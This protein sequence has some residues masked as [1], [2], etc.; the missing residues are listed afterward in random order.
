MLFEE[1]LFT[2]VMVILT[3]VTLVAFPP[4]ALGW[5]GIGVAHLLL[6]DR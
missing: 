3:I 6:R 4:S 1:K 2:V 5:L